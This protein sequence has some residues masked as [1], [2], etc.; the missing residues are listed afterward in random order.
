[1][2]TVFDT[3]ALV[4]AHAMTHPRFA[5]AD[6]QIQAAEQPALCAHSL[7][8]CY[9]VMTSHPQLR[10]PPVKVE[11]VLNRLAETWTVLTL[12]SADYL[13][14]VARCRELGLQGGAIYDTLIA[15]AAVKAGATQV[16]TLN[17]KHFVRLG[18]DMRRIV[19]TPAD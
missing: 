4:A 18:E 8:E 10:Y 14:A 7:A 3:S 6:A 5:W 16:V 1:M 17:A 2:V 9:A 12:S 13:A 19:V 15:E 11:Q